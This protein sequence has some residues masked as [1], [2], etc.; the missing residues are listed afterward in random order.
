[1][2]FEFSHEQKLLLDSVDA[3]MARH[4]PPAE[5]RARDA[6]ADPP[7]HLLPLMGE[8]GF[9]GLPVPE[10]Q[11]G[12]GGDWRTMALVQER[13]G[14]HATIAAVL[15]NRVTCFG[16]MTLLTSGSA[17][18]QAEFLE[19]LIA[20]R[21]SFALAL[22]EPNAGSDAGGITSRARKTDAGWR[23]NGRKTWISGAAAATRMVV[24]CRTGEAPRGHQGVTL[25]LVDPDAPGVSMTLLDK[26]GSRCSLS[27]DI[28][29]DDV[30]VPDDAVVGVVDRGFDAL[31]R[32]LFYA[33]CGLSAAVVG[34]AQAAVDLALEHA[35]TRHQFG[36]PIGSF[37]AIAHR[38]ARMQTEV[39]QA[40]LLTYRLAW[41]IDTGRPCDREAAQ[42][43]WSATETLK[44]VSEDGLQIMASAGYAADSDM[45]RYWRD[46]RL[47]T[48]G[49]GASEIQ[50]D[51]I[52]R[53]M[54]VG[55][56][57]AP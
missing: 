52:A 54:G 46:A 39:D 23:I 10:E 20:G 1:M 15:F 12:S 49:E 17:R 43:K 14:Y 34:T 29:F 47:Y 33:R 8:A 42:A 16:I 36:R 22:S 48:F 19:A 38:L 25:F 45:Q 51:L 41:L 24:A 7:D 31:R 13:L 6:A 21:A 3:F 5:V 53:D 18:Q 56:R 50:L 28:G 9:L 57:A 27:Y 26:V 44:R 40:R 11:G 32:T 30:V 35:R 2:D 37:Q 4:L 55:E